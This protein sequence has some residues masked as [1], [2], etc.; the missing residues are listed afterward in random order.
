[1][2]FKFR[3]N[4]KRSR[5]AALADSDV[6]WSQK[7]LRLLEIHESANTKFPSEPS[8]DLSSRPEVPI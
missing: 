1:M 2:K 7:A 6:G 8:A 4:P 3:S 5:V